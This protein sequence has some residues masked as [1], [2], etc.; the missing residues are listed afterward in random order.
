MCETFRGSLSVPA[1]A[2]RVVAG[3]SL[4]GAGAGRKTGQEGCVR[5]H[6]CDLDADSGPGRPGLA[7]DIALLAPTE[8][9]RAE[10]FRFARHRDRYIR[11]RAFLRRRLAEATGHP[12]AG[13]ELVEG[14][15]GKPALA[16]GTVDFNLSHS[17]ALAVLAVSTAGP[18]GIDVE[19]IDPETDVKG[20]SESCFLAPERAVLDGLEGL[21]LRRRF[22]AFWTA[23]EALMKLTG[24]G[25]A[26]PPHAIALRLRRGWP[27]GFSRPRIPGAVLSY[28]DPGRPDA[29]CCLVRLEPAAAPEAGA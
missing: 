5:L 28:P 1:A 27:V 16:C 11:G 8:R 24:Q 10:R 12:A 22:F 23:K 26:L 29:V 14:V 6:Q 3:A 15:R 17:G 19:L 20:L 9:A 25:M 7:G 21:A 4:A 18:V 13:L 2:R